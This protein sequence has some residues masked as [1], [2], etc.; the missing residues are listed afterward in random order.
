[1]N[2]EKYSLLLSKAPLNHRHLSVC[3]KQKKVS[4]N[5]GLYE[6]KRKAIQKKKKKRRRISRTRREAGA[7]RG[8]DYI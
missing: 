6:I 8:R 7:A 2:S 4:L 1:M 5:L 3:G